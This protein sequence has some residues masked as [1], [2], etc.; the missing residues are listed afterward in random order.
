MTKLDL[1]IALIIFR[2]SSDSMYTVIVNA[3]VYSICAI[4]CPVIL[5]IQCTLVGLYV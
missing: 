4:R 5:L 2:I 1:I 3:S